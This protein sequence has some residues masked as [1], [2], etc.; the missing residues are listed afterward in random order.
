MSRL[1]ATEQTRML[2][3]TLAQNTDPKFQVCV[4]SLGLVTHVFFTRGCGYLREL[5]KVKSRIKGVLRGKK[6][7]IN[8]NKIKQDKV[9][10]KRFLW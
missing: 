5:D 6:K 7:E 9:T 10:Q 1:A 4:L 3:H 2:A 8:R